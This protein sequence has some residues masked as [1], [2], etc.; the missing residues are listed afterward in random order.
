MPLGPLKP[1]M[2]SLHN[3]SL[4]NI[5]IINSAEHKM[6]MAMHIVATRSDPRFYQLWDDLVLNAGL[7]SNFITGVQLLVYVIW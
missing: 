6:W 7:L 2:Q 3:Y 1:P 4:N 5:P